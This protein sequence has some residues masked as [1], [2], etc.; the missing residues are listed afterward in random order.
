MVNLISGGEGTKKKRGGMVVSTQ[1][2]V[3]LSPEK[4]E[5]PRKGVTNKKEGLRT[6]KKNWAKKGESELHRKKGCEFFE[7]YYSPA[8]GRKGDRTQK[9]NATPYVLQEGNGRRHRAGKFQT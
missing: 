4:K 3:P 9:K 6:N 5:K 2:R 1:G 8:G 7:E